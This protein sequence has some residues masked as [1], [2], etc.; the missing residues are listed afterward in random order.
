MVVVPKA[1]SRW[2]VSQVYD[3]L[4][5][6][7][8]KG[9]FRPG[10]ALSEIKMAAHYG[11]SRTPI[12]QAFHRLSVEGLLS[13]VPQVGS[14]VAPIQLS[15]VRDA[16]FVR[17]TVE[18]RAVRSAALATGD[19]KE[20]VLNGLLKEQAGII[21]RHDHYGFFSSDE[22]LHRALMLIAGHPHVWDFILSMKTQLDRLRYL[23]LESQDWLEMIFHQHEQLVKCVLAH[24]ADGAVA[25][26]ETHLH[27]ASLALE[28]IA[29]DHAEF[30]E[31]SPPPPGGTP[32][33][34]F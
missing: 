17:Q 33:K 24:D 5:G 3:D 10:E 12:R 23:S 27:S 1:E 30:F 19:E 21:S 11:L 2:S 14:F 6:R 15:A 7:I 32:P 18:C 26:M 20:R 16:Q 28:K 13:I 25:L 9:E 22:D 4:S 34:S 29:V 31:D 8:L